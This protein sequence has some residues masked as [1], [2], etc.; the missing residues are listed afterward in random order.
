M[1]PAE[2]EGIVLPPIIIINQYN[3][4][5]K[6][7]RC[8]NLYLCKR[9]YENSKNSYHKDTNFAQLNLSEINKIKFRGFKQFINRLEINS[10]SELSVWLIHSPGLIF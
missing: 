5:R 1:L 6:I 3:I 2:R 4:A 8:P 10:F 9:A 7:L